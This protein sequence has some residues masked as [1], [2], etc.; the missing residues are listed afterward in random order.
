MTIVDGVPT[1]PSVGPGS[2]KTIVKY[3]HKQ[4]DEAIDAFLDGCKPEDD[5]AILIDSRL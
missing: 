1:F 3:N 5:V 2:S 4:I